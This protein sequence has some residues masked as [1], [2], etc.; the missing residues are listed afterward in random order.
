ML[1]RLLRVAIAISTLLVAVRVSYYQLA[2]T[3]NLF[4]DE[5]YILLSLRQYMAGG[6]LYSQVF[7]QYGPVFYF[8]QSGLFHA[9]RQPLTHN[10]GRVVTLLLWIAAA[11]AGGWLLYKLSR[12]MLLASAACLTMML[13]GASMA[14][15]PNHPEHVILLLLVVACGTALSLKPSR[16]VTLGALGAAL[17]F[18]KINVGLFFFVA[19]FGSLVCLLRPG[20]FRRGAGLLFV[21]YFLLAPVALMH[22]DLHGWAR[23]FCL[24]QVLGGA[25]AFLIAYFISPRSVA[26]RKDLLCTAAG[27]VVVSIVVVLATSLQAMPFHTL[28]QGVLLD[29][30]RQP[31]IFQLPLHVP[32]RTFVAAV[33]PAFAVIMVY[34]RNQKAGGPLAWIELVRG[35]AGLFIVAEFLRTGNISPLA[36]L[37]LP[38][39][40]LRGERQQWSLP[41]F[42]PRLFITLLAV[43][44]ILENYPVVGP[45][46]SVAAGPIILWSFLCIHD[47]ARDLMRRFPDLARS[48]ASMPSAFT[49][50]SALLVLCAEAQLL[51]SG[52][53]RTRSFYPPSTLPGSSSIYMAPSTDKRYTWLVTDIH[54]NCDMLF[55][56]PGIDSL[57]LWSGV[58]TPNGFNLTAWVK[59]FR[60]DRQ[61]EI[62]NILESNANACVVVDPQRGAEW[63]T[64]DSD[65]AASPLASHI[66]REMPRVSLIDGYEIRVNP[67]RTQPWVDMAPG[68]TPRSQAPSDQD[69]H[70]SAFNMAAQE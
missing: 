1:T 29:P 66:L 60:A 28:L 39:S 10:G 3:F 70:L 9:L 56:L 42:L 15:Q 14:G 41:E 37:C 44:E 40:L 12:S 43:T 7:S 30:L 22:R 45:Q 36:V 13:A 54:R 17:C 59:G 63:G 57:N 4:D 2:T 16:L 38:F 49:L 64:T 48:R 5:G 32:F 19:L 50:A 62:L 6:H 31:Q 51:R 11:L 25:A 20:V 35:A 8:I 47:G 24:S 67:Q 52:V 61:Q 33:L 46:L 27:A 21:A 34:W 26:A 69:L 23:G 65:L 58:P 18:I 68:A 55:T 53:W